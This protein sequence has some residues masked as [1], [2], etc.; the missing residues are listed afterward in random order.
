MCEVKLE[1]VYFLRIAEP[2]IYLLLE[3]TLHE[4]VTQVSIFLHYRQDD[5]ANVF[6]IWVLLE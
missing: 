5:E 3:G 4:I 1:T 6:S 2:I